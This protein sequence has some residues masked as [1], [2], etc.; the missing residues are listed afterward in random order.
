MDSKASEDIFPATEEQRRIWVETQ[1]QCASPPS[2]MLPPLLI[3]SK[4]QWDGEKWVEPSEPV[5]KQKYSH[6]YKNVSTLD[7]IDVYR[8]LHLFNVTDPCIQHAVKKLLVAGGRGAGKDISKDIKE[9]Q[10]CLAR[11]MEM[12]DEETEHLLK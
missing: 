7:F 12:R 11:W 4:Q 2:D 9:A 3:P 8:V 5:V 1:M 10:D 6:Y